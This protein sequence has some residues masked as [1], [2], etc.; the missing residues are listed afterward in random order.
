MVITEVSYV[1][2]ALQLPF[3]ADSVAKLIKILKYYN[4]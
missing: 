2:L 1:K 4:A 3:T